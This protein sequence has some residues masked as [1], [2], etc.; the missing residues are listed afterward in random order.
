VRSDTD[1][2]AGAVRGGDDVKAGDWVCVVSLEDSPAAR[3]LRS[4]A[5]GVEGGWVLDR[6][7]DGLRLWNE[8]DLRPATRAEIELAE[9]S[10]FA[11]EVA[12]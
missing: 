8:D 3:L 10:G 2:D 7:I 4:L 6:R 5:P 12:P 1:A 11:E 9:R